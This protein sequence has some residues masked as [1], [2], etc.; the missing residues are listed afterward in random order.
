M[1]SSWQPILAHHSNN[2]KPK[3]VKIDKEAYIINK[4]YQQENVTIIN[5]WIASKPYYL[6]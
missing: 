5:V 2:F 1:E 3:L 6:L 4:K